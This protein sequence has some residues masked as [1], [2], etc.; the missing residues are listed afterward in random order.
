MK[1]STRYYRTGMNSVY[2]TVLVNLPQ[3]CVLSSI[4]YLSQNAVSLMFV[5]T[6]QFKFDFTLF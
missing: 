4:Q 5:N 3:N 1:H 2:K 6:A